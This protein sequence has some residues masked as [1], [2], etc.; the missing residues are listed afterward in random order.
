[1]KLTVTVNLNVRV[2]KPS[3]NAPCFQYIAQGSTIEVDGNL[4]P[5]DK[6]EGIDTWYRDDAGNYYWSG[7]FK[8]INTQI[9]NEI[10][11]ISPIIFEKYIEE[12]IKDRT[13]IN[14]VNYNDLLNIDSQ[15]KNSDG[16]NTIIGILD[17]YI[18]ENL[19]FKNHIIH[20]NNKTI[21]NP[22]TSHGCAM[23][24]LIAG[25]SGIFGV[26]KSSTILELPIYNLD[27][28]QDDNM[29]IEA[30]DYFSNHYS[31]DLIILNISQSL[32]K[33]NDTKFRSLASKENLI[34]VSSAGTD[35][36]LLKDELQFPSS[37]LN[38]ISV[39]SISNS[40]YESNFNQYFN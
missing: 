18:N 23:A 33:V 4:Y 28:H 19:P 35:S 27:G 1:M 39:G 9:Q 40:F 3:V 11:I 25:N 15:I 26:A 8:D 34:I 37:L 17:H 30:L 12:N 20:S 21:N 10:P 22:P 36:E 7:G 13:L 6:Y 5:G 24:G 14:N 29:I 2:G 32:S 31:R 38:V 16:I